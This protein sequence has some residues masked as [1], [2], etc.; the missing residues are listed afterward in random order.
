MKLTLILS[1]LQ[2]PYHDK[3]AIGAVCNLLADRA[4]DI[5]EV[6][7]VGDFFDFLAVSSYA[8]G[9][10][11]EDGKNLQREIDVAT[12]VMSDIGKAYPGWKTRIKGNHDDRLNKYLNTAAKG[13]R[14]LNA[15]D[16]DTLTF[17]NEYGWETH[18]EPYRL[19]SGTVAVH[20]LAI[21]SKSGYTAH[22]HLDRLEGNIVHGH[23]HRAGVV[24]R[25]VGRRTRWA[26][27]VGCLMDKAKAAYLGP[28]RAA[29][30]QLGIGAVY[31]EGPYSWPVLIDLKPDRSLVF[32]GKRYRP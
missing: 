19:A 32:E 28:A 27:E 20:G 30:W 29:D 7:Q 31:S 24:Y 2:L 12:Q 15:L 6:H 16:Y 11:D 4:T 14:G 22:A 10:P 1:D 21:R 3:R 8:R 23:T 26:M 17:A 18:R 13:L 25:T 5:D 9:T